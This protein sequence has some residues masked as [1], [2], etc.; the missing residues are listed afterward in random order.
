[1]PDWQNGLN[2]VFTHA[3]L[4]FAVLVL[5]S[6]PHLPAKLVTDSYSLFL[7]CRFEP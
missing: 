5:S 4:T 6:K 7:W 3:L 1:M 2:A